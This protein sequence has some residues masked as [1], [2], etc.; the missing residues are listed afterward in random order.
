MLFVKKYNFKMIKNMQLTINIVP[1]YIFTCFTA[2]TFIN[3]SAMRFKLNFKNKSAKLVN[4]TIA[5]FGHLQ[6]FSHYG[7]VFG[8]CLSDTQ[9]V[10]C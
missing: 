7:R 9:K 5:I 8:K 10:Y 1:Q 6:W 4:K 3:L 2:F